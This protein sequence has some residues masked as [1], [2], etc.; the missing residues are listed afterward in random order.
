M[1]LEKIPDQ[2]LVRILE[3]IQ[4]RIDEGEADFDD[5]LFDYTNMEMLESVCGYFGIKINDFTDKSF[6]VK[7]YMDNPNFETE[8]IKRPT[9]ETY[10]VIHSESVREY[11]T[12]FYN[13]RMKSYY[14]LDNNIM[15]ELQSSG[16]Y[17]YWDGSHYDT[18][19]HD[20]EVIEDKVES[21][22]KVKRR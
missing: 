15:Y 12:N 18:D 14:P 2:V 19:Y 6:F 1:E 4:E 21:I 16:E 8:P 20:T 10:D 13:T 17:E 9:L 3:A 5:D 22:E 7:L 11:R